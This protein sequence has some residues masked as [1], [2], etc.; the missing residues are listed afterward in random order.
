M[1]VLGALILSGILWFFNTYGVSAWIWVWAFVVAVQL[2][3]MYLAPVV[4]MPLFN[5]FEPIEDGVLKERI[6]AYAADQGF[7]LSGIFTM[8]GS[9]RSSKSN[10]FFTG[11]GSTHVTFKR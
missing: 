4:L 8:D 7:E 9:K 11:F 1:I 10:A 2:F 5:R 6:E 3:M